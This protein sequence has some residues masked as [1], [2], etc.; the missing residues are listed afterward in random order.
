[1]PFLPVLRPATAAII[2]AL[3][4]TLAS[5]RSAEAG[6]PVQGEIAVMGGWAAVT[7]VGPMNPFGFGAGGRAGLS[8]YRI[9]FGVEGLDYAGKVQGWNALQFGGDV[10]YDFR[11]A[12]EVLIL[13][14]QVGF[15]QLVVLGSSDYEK[16]QV[17]SGLL[18]SGKP[19]YV[20]PGL[21]ALVTPVPTFFVGADAN[22]LVLPSAQ[23]TEDGPSAHA[24]ITLHLQVGFRI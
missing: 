22:L 6:G 18:G 20:E 12:G 14:P 16:E 10:G 11:V 9:Y 21:T 2:T 4:V 15:G 23:S 7:D 8:V 1:M 24:G 19:F 17:G 13:R 5:A 3:L